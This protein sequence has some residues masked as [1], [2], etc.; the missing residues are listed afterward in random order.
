MSNY[1]DYISDD[2]YNE[3][4]YLTK[5][6]EEIAHF[7][8]DDYMSCGA[9]R[10]I[11]ITNWQQKFDDNLEKDIENIFNSHYEYLKGTMSNVLYRA[12]EHHAIDL[13]SLVQ[14]HL[15]RDYDMSVFYEDPDL[16]AP[17]LSDFL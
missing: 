4:E 6:R 7:T 12:D 11:L 9:T 5:K 15:V 1:A 8:L 2:D 13:V 3:D 14:H 10:S 16:A 17:L